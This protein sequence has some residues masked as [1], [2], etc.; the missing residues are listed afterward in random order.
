MTGPPEKST[1]PPSWPGRQ[2]HRMK[3]RSKEQL[4]QARP[5]EPAT[6]PF[7]AKEALANSS[8]D[9]TVPDTSIPLTRRK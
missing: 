5:S 8:A 4:A 2:T 3:K 6:K 9:E 7:A 1:R